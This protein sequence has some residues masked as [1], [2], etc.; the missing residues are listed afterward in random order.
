[1][2]HF[3]NSVISVTKSCENKQDVL[4]PSVMSHSAMFTIYRQ[5]WHR[6]ATLVTVNYRK[7]VTKL[8]FLF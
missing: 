2:F 3:T 4:C 5:L 1:M 6:S 7:S 8:N